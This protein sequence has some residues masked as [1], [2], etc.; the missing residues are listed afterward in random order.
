MSWPKRAAGFWEE[1]PVFRLLLPFVAGILGYDA[2][3]QARLLPLITLAAALLLAL[4]FLNR[5]R[6]FSNGY[7]ALRFLNLWL[8]MAVV[9]YGLSAAN[10]LRNRPNWDWKTARRKRRFAAPH[11][12][13]AK[14]HRQNMAHGN[15]SA[16][17]F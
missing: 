6:R 14:S 16:F 7:L 17:R 4:F 10:D 3:P 1:A 11:F 2:F 12:H 5:F 13:P 8:F 15:R 9:G